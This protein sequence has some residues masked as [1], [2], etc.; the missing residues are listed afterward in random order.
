MSTPS[1]YD[2]W[3]DPGGPGG[4]RRGPSPGVARALYV[5]WREAVDEIAGDRALRAAVAPKVFNT[6][7]ADRRAQGVADE[8]LVASFKAFAVAVLRGPVRV[9]HG[10]LWRTYAG[11]WARWVAAVPAPATAPLRDRTRP[12][13]WQ[14]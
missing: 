7:C 11:S 9:R 8:Q 2:G 12:P 6:F 10:D 3:D 14:R 5:A 4:R 1:Y 13:G